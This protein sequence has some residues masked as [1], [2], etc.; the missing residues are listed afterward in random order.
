MGISYGDGRFDCADF[1]AM[2]LDEVF[3]Q[4]LELP[5]HNQRPGGAAG[6]RALIGRLS[7]KLAERLDAPCVGALCLMQAPFALGDV[8]HIGVAFEELGQWW[9]LHNFREMG[10]VHLHRVSDLDLMGI[11]VEGFYACV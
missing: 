3:G 9:I 2:V 10:G 1:S 5:P 4:K 6:R 7:R 11:K 8:Y